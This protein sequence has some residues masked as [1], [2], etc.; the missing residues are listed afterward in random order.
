MVPAFLLSVL[1]LTFRQLNFFKVEDWKVCWKVVPGS[2]LRRLRDRSRFYRNMA[3]VTLGQ[4]VF[5][6]EHDAELENHEEWH[7]RQQMVFNTPGFVAYCVLALVWE[8][9]VLTL[10]LLY[11]FLLLYGL[12]VLF[13]LSTGGD[14]YW[15][16]HFEKQ[17]YREDE[18]TEA[19]GD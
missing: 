11:G 5:M 8:S 15:D 14:W 3:A 2:W 13:A 4:C 10:P 18:K 7:V 9:W 12:D 1:L 17:A 6:L 19:L 16:L